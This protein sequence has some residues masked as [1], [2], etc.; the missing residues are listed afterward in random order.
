MDR[1]Q[2]F[3]SI[4]RKPKSGIFPRKDA[5]VMRQSGKLFAADE[6]LVLLPISNINLE[7]TQTSK[8]HCTQCA[9]LGCHG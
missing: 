8:K 2:L 6:A 3:K 4:S 5:L 9:L 7:G 1:V